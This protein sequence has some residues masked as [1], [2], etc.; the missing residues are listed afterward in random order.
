MDYTYGCAYCENNAHEFTHMI[1]VLTNASAL[2][3]K[4]DEIIDDCLLRIQLDVFL[5]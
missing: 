1:D 4:I 3:V 2:S 5:Y